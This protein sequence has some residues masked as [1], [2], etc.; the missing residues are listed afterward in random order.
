MNPIEI[1]VVLSVYFTGAYIIIPLHYYV[2]V[3]NFFGVFLKCETTSN[4]IKLTCITEMHYEIL[5]V[6]Y[7]FC[8]NYYSFTD[9][10]EYV[11]EV[12]VR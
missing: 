12:C 7:G 11:K 1:M 5:S 8:S 2:W 3:K 10:Q 6:E 4:I 9:L